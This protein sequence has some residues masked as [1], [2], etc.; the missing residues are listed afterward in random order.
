[1]IPQSKFPYKCMV[2]H[3]QKHDNTINANGKIVKRKNVLPS[4]NNEK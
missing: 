3:R 1:M 2:T 4:F